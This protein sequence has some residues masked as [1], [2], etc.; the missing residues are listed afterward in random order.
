VPHDEQLIT[1]LA[2]I[3]LVQGRRGAAAE[4][5]AGWEQAVRRLGLGEPSPGPR[6]LLLVRSKTGGDDHLL[7]MTPGNR[8]VPRPGAADP[9]AEIA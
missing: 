1:T 4:L 8:G 2:G 9:L 3:H 7:S 5:V 6:N